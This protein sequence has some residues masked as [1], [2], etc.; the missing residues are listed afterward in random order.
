MGGIIV[1]E[2]LVIACHGDG[3]YVTIPTFT[4]GI[5]FFGVPHRGSKHA[6]WGRIV[7]R[8]IERFTGQVNEL[9]LNSI[10]SGS[11]HHDILN[12]GF[13][14]LPKRYR[15]FSFCETRPEKVN[16]GYFAIVGLE[17]FPST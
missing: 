9:F 5:V 16:D 2:A 17:S 7:A 15:F 11:A 6:S 10:D 3:A 13:E 8:I 14:P 12:A 4:C 1:K